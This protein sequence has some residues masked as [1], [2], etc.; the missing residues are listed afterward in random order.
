MYRV[1]IPYSILVQHFIYYQTSCIAC[2]SSS[3][4]PLYS[5]PFILIPHYSFPF[6]F[7][8]LYSFL[9]IF[10]PLYSFPYILIP[11]YIHSPLF[12]PLYIHSHLYSF[13][14]IFIP[15]YIH[16]LLYSFP[17]FILLYIHFPLYSF[18][19]ICIPL[20][21]QYPFIF[22]LVYS[23]LST[24]DYEFISTTLTLH[25]PVHPFIPSP[26]SSNPPSP[27]LYHHAQSHQALGLT[28]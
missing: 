9:F 22:I 6:I 4:I 28:T 26:H 21:I 14:F 11:L 3:Y 25:I 16:T 18:L 10:I 24:I 15:L 8:P 1:Y 17:G 23:I 5:F 2:H 7:I 12:I 19:F 20:Y 27:R 13:P